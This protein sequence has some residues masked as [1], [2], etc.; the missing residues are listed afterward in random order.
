MRNKIVFFTLLLSLSFNQLKGNDSLKIE[1]LISFE[2]MGQHN[3]SAL[4]SNNDCWHCDRGVVEDNPLFHLGIYTGID[5]TLTINDNY[6][7]R[8]GLYLEE[9][10][11]SGGNNTLS[12]IVV[13]PRILLEV[14]DTIRGRKRDIGVRLKGGDYWDEDVYD[15]LRIYNIDYQAFEGTLSLGNWDAS[16]MTIGDLSKNVGLNLHQTYRLSLAYSTS[17]FKNLAY[18]TL[19]ELVDAPRGTHPSDRDLN[20]TYFSRYKGIDNLTLE[21]QFEVRA[22]SLISNA[23]AVGV[24][25]NHQSRMFHTSLALRYY[26]QEFNTGYNGRQPRYTGGVSRYIGPQLYPLK[27]YYRPYSQ[28]A[29]YT[30]FSQSDLFTIAFNASWNGTLYKKL[31]AF[32]ELDINYIH[33]IDKQKGL[34]YPFYNA[35]FQVN[36]LKN[37]V[38]KF[39]ITNKHMNLRDFYQTFT[40]SKVPFLSLGVQMNLDNFQLGKRYVVTK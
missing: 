2:T 24:K 36:F 11:H 5:H 34:L 20:I 22:N 17:S 14:S 23:F 16:A 40:M 3:L 12:N 9:R 8:T 29:A 30:H 31:G 39:S 37:F 32:Y 10:S 6:H 21:G 28:W 7:V 38:G 27:N 15:M 33:N 25:A 26:S 4:S 35:G 19:N 13:F 18:L 1:S